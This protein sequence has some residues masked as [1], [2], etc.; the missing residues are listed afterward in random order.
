MKTLT[1]N[2]LARLADL[3]PADLPCPAPSAL[4]DALAGQGVDWQE[5]RP[6]ERLV[7]GRLFGRSAERQALRPAMELL[8]ALEVPI[9]DLAMQVVHDPGLRAVIQKKIGYANDGRDGRQRLG[10]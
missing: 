6:L 8:A 10:R 3:V 5:T 2:Q 7:L 1:P 4:A 9:R